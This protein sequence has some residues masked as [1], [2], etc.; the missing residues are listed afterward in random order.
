MC[1]E[2]AGSKKD[3]YNFD[4]KCF[5]IDI[6]EHVGLPAKVGIPTIWRFGNNAPRAGEWHFARGGF[7]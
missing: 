6:I 7:V 5:F 2:H 1:K 3:A 4:I